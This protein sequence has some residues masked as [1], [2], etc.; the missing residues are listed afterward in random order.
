M[1]RRRLIKK[2]VKAFPDRP[3]SFASQITLF[4][5]RVGSGGGG[6]S[7]DSGNANNLH[8][9]SKRTASTKHEKLEFNHSRI[10]VQVPM[11]RRRVRGNPRADQAFRTVGAAAPGRHEAP[12]A[13]TRRCSR[14]QAGR[15]EQGHAIPRTDKWQL[16][17]Q[18]CERATGPFC[19]R[20]GSETLCVRRSC[21]KAISL[22][23]SQREALRR[24]REKV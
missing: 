5:R 23:L 11:S 19:D 15:A 7:G 1:T 13:E 3:L 4:A 17:T 22:T 24:R 2:D 9:E 14:S 20:K 12:Q 16:G 10:R 6:D 8:N 21:A 18:D